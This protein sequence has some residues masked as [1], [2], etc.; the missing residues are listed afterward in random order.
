LITRFR[1]YNR[2]TFV[3]ISP[4][5]WRCYGSNDGINWTL[6]KEATNEIVPLTTTNYTDGFY[7]HIVNNNNTYSYIGF[8]VNKV[9]SNVSSGILNFAEL[10]LWGKEFISITPIYTSSNVL[11]NSSN[12]LSNSIFNSSNNNSIYTS[13]SSNILSNS[14]F[15]SSNNNSIYTSNS[16]NINFNFTSNSSNILSNSIFNSSN[17]NSI[18]TSNSSNI[19]SNSIF[20]SS[21]INSIYTSNSSNINFNYT[22]NSLFSNLNPIY[23]SSNAVKSIVEFDMPVVKK[24]RKF[25]CVVSTAINI[26]GTT[27]Y[28]YDIDLRKYIS[29]G[30]LEYTNDPYRIFNIQ[31]FYSTSYFSTIVNGL[32]DVIDTDIFMCDRANPSQFGVAGLNICNIGNTN[33]PNLRTIPPNNLF[34]MDNGTGS[35]DYISIVS[36][37]VA[38]VSVIISCYLS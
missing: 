18:Y 21:N 37:R 5:L 28:K 27:F 12:I 20:N 16:S 1:F 24:H 15:N 25:Y 2:P 30:F 31:I 13:N 17:N 33:N 34:L 19:L 26:N 8:V 32:P 10:Q 38:D 3:N 11:S 23:A 9:V 35:I 4:S 14:I 22:S 6:I 7:E 29:K 36:R